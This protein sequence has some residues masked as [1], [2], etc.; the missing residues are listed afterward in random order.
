MECKFWL[1]V[2]EVE[3]KEAFTLNMTPASTRELKKM[4]YQD[5]DLNVDSW[6]SF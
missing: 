4:I 6:K 3:M 1:L 5:F 2:D